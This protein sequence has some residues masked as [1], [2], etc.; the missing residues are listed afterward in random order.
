MQCG[1]AFRKKVDLTRHEVV[2]SGIR[3]YQCNLCDKRFQR[4]THLY[5]HQRV[6]DEEGPYFCDFC[7]KLF[8]RAFYLKCHISKTHSTT[9][10]SPEAT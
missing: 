5:C 6:H 1:K 8:T 3:P 9:E 7:G 10:R 4:K 2:H